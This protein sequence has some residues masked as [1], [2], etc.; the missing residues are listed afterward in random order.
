MKVVLQLCSLSVQ[1]TQ[2]DLCPLDAFFHFRR[3][4]FQLCQRV[5]LAGNFLLQFFPMDELGLLLQQHLVQPGKFFRPIHL[6]GDKL[7]TSCAQNPANQYNRP[8]PN[9]LFF[10]LF[11]LARCFPAAILVS[12]VFC[13]ASS[14]AVL[15]SSSS[16]SVGASP[17]NRA[18]V[19]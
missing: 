13:C 11:E 19:G 3:L 16:A 1:R 12:C 9:Q 14:H 17:D 5:C 2:R 18:G 10:L 4:L 7:L 8:C 6:T 15:A